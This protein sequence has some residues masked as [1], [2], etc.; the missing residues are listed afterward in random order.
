MFL[1]VPRFPF[2]PKQRGNNNNGRENPGLQNRRNLET[3][4]F[5]VHTSSNFRSSNVAPYWDI[6]DRSPN[7][8]PG[9]LWDILIQAHFSFAAVEGVCLHQHQHA[10]NTYCDPRECYCCHGQEPRAAQFWLGPRYFLEGQGEANQERPVST[11]LESAVC[12]PGIMISNSCSSYK[13]RLCAQQN[14]NCLWKYWG[15]WAW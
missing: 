5:L 3:S 15:S 1:G 10:P 8:N 14:C 13:A 9:I 12:K 7:S 11:P 2:P 4:F 6:Q